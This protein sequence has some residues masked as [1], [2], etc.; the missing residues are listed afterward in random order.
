MPPPKIAPPSLMTTEDQA[1]EY[2]RVMGAEAAA[3]QERAAR[4]T[5]G[6]CVCTPRKVRRKWEG[7]TIP[8]RRQVHDRECPKFQPWMGEV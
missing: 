2:R 6:Q 4:L 3:R 8:S 5:K 1:E 7:S